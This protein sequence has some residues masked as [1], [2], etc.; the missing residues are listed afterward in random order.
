SLVSIPTKPVTRFRAQPK[1]SKS[2]QELQRLSEGSKEVATELL[3]ALQ[4]LKVSDGKNKAWTSFRQALHSVLSAERIDQLSTRLE[5]YQ[6]QINTA[7]LLS[8][9]DTIKDDRDGK[10]TYDERVNQELFLLPSHVKTWQYELIESSL[11]K[12]WDP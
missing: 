7:L 3:A 10:V 6:A 9:R 1:L 8:L 5:R 11:R 2:E 4:K 12:R